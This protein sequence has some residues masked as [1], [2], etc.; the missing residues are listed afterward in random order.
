MIATGNHEYLKIRC[1]LQHAQDDRG[2]LVV[3][4]SHRKPCHSERSLSNIIRTRLGGCLIVP[5]ILLFIDGR[6][7]ICFRKAS[8]SQPSNPR[9]S[10]ISEVWGCAKARRR[11]ADGLCA[12]Q[13]AATQHWGVPTPQKRV[14]I[15]LLRLSIAKY[16][17]ECNCKWF[18]IC[19]R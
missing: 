18:K 2:N 3:A 8:L 14:R 15:M 4:C 12:L 13:K 9:R 17:R 19:K 5:G 6:Q 16:D 7:P 1:A 11:F 10:E